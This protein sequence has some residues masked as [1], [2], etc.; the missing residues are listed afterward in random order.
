MGLGLFRVAAE[1]DFAS[2]SVFDFGVTAIDL[3]RGTDAGE[4]EISAA[5]A[6]G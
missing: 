3:H 4:D 1:R 6:F 2:L 5:H